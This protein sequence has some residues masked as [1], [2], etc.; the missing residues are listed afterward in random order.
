[1][2][3]ATSTVPNTFGPLGPT[4][5]LNLLDA[6]YTAIVN[7]LNNVANRVVM[8]ADSGAANAYVVVPLPVLTSYAAGQFFAFTTTNPC[9]SAS[10]IN[11][12]ALGVVTLYKLVGGAQA[13]L[14]TGDIL[15]GRTYLCATDG[16]NVCVLNPSN[17]I[18]APVLITTQT[19]SAVATVD[20]TGLTGTYNTLLFRFF[21]LRPANDAVNLLVRVSEGA[22]FLSGA[23]NYRYA[24]NSTNDSGATGATVSVGDTSIQ[25]AG[26]IGNAASRG[27]D[28]W[29]EICA[30]TASGGANVSRFIRSFTSGLDNA[31]QVATRTMGGDRNVAP[32]NAI[33]GVRFLFS[34]G[35]VAAGTFEMWGFQ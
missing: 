19:V 15:S 35:N 4:V 14:V 27:V 5:A 24:G 8:A 13:A 2:T 26:S 7:Y 30:L 22:G 29:M 9:T 16:A 28:G 31:G 1:M 23:G 12:N 3:S 33:D 6:N 25:I 34:A 20:F 32:P 18:A 21:N 11:C 17:L 10:T